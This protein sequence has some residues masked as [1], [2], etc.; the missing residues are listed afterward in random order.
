MPTHCCCTKT[1]T[2]K[3]ETP[4]I[5]IAK[6]HSISCA[7]SSRWR[8][9]IID[10]RERPGDVGRQLLLRQRLHAA[11]RLHARREIAGDEEVGA[12]SLAHRAEQLVH[13]GAGLF[14]GQHG[15]GRWGFDLRTRELASRRMF[16]TA[17]LASKTPGD[18]AVVPAPPGFRPLDSPP[19]D[20]LGRVSMPGKCAFRPVDKTLPARR[21]SPARPA[22]SR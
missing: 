5:V 4:G 12:A 14:F 3:R 13:V 7:N 1:L 19:C 10:L 6:L 11:V 2:R 15:H 22:A 17:E 18:R 8:S 20:P 9:F 16:G 21:Q